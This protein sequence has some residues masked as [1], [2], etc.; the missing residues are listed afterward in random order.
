MKE[1]NFYQELSKAPDLP[2]EL[3][4]T[5]TKEAKHGSSKRILKFAL[6][7]AAV[8]LFAVTLRVTTHP[9][10]STDNLYSLETVAIEYAKLDEFDNDFDLEYNLLN[11]L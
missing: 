4:D 11:D 10:E 9:Q 7:S 1:D 2:E 5:I 6:A 8:L 3:F